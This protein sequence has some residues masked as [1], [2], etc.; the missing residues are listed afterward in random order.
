VARGLWRSFLGSTVKGSRQ[1]SCPVY[2]ERGP[3]QMASTTMRAA[4]RAGTCSLSCR[5]ERR[6]CC[7]GGISARLCMGRHAL[8]GRVAEEVDRAAPDTFWW[9]GDHQAVCSRAH[10]LAGRK[11]VRRQLTN[12]DGPMMFPQAQFTTSRITS[13]VCKITSQDGLSAGGRRATP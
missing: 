12:K 11:D 1:R 6:R 2:G 9:R 5:S 4:P 7:P 10:W 13:F 3:L 8:L